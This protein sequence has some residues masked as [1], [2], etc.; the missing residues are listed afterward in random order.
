MQLA[1]YSW[2]NK[3]VGIPSAAHQHMEPPPATLSTFFHIKHL[4]HWTPHFATLIGC[5]ALPHW[6]PHPSTQTGCHALL[7]KNLPATPAPAESLPFKPPPTVALIWCPLTSPHHT[8][9][10]HPHLLCDG[11]PASAASPTTQGP[12]LPCLLAHLSRWALPASPCTC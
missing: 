1:L 5:Y 6:T 8:M 9:P 2:H 3:Q 7:H 11:T 4:P 10:R 12:S